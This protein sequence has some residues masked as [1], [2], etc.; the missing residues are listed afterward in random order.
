MLQTLRDPVLLKCGSTVNDGI[1]ESLFVLLQVGI[2]TNEHFQG[3]S[4][5]HSS[6]LSLE[7]S[8]MEYNKIGRNSIDKVRVRTSH[9]IRALRSQSVELPCAFP[10]TEKDF[11]RLALRSPHTGRDVISSGPLYLSR[12]FSYKLQVDDAGVYRTGC[13]GT[14]TVR[15]LTP[16]CAAVN[17]KV[18]LYREAPAAGGAGDGG[19]GGGAAAAAAGS[20]MVGSSGSGPSAGTSLLGFG[21]QDELSAPPVL[22]AFKWLTHGE[23]QTEFNCSV[24]H[25]GKSKYCFRFVFNHSRMPSLAQTCLVVHRSVGENVFLMSPLSQM[26]H[27][28]SIKYYLV[29]YYL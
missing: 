21:P 18:Q 13:D 25:P 8:Y 5:D 6:A 19:G 26:S 2:S 17:G 1:H 29:L 7:V 4:D 16:P 3:C 14:M 20:I 27:L 23:N 22:L 15:L 9:P 11:V 10:F 12:I 28:G 24:F